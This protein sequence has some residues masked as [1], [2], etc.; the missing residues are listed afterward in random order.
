M[1]GNNSHIKA[2]RMDPKLKTNSSG[3]CYVSHM[4]KPLTLI[5][6]IQTLQNSISS[7]HFK[8]VLLVFV[9]KH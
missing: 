1:R 5:I 3:R 9:T 4:Y 6:Y 8:P 2:H 7:Q